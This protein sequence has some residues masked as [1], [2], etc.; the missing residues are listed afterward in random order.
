MV[1]NIP[2]LYQ[3]PEMTSGCHHGVINPRHLIEPPQ[4]NSKTPAACPATFQNP[5][6]QFFL[7]RKSPSCLLI[8]DQVLTHVVINPADTVKLRLSR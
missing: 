8:M 5:D 7:I 6:N 4:E 2:E 3:V 1:V